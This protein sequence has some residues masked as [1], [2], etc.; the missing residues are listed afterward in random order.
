MPYILSKIV[1]M[2]IAPGNMFSLLLLLSV[3]LALSPSPRR[4]KAGRR[5]CLGLAVAVFL[6]GLLPVG[7][8]MLLPLENLFPPEKLARIDGILLLAGDEDP[9]L[10][11]ARH[12]AS[13]DIS[14]RRHMVFAALARDYP[15]AQ[16]VFSG[17][18]NALMPVGTLTNADVARMAMQELGLSAEKVIY[19]NASQNTYENAV[20]SA[21]RVRPQPDQN[22]LLVTSANH[23]P[24]ALLTFRK[25]GWNVYPAPAGY[26]TA[27]DDSAFLDFNLMKHMQEMHTAFY[28][29][30]GL[31][32]YKIL[33]RI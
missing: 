14:A 6:V 2:L 33:G 25:A 30:G 32:T 28:E 22:W 16:L 21:R 7:R 17:G 1:K 15:N 26:H 10:T 31:L 12:Q 4:Q 19:E 9:Y 23:M 11:E 18:N 29:Y 27:P 3:I 13:V 5:L 8:W 20:F 24:R